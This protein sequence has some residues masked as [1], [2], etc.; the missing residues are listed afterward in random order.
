MS[1]NTQDWKEEFD[2]AFYRIMGTE[3]DPDGEP[4]IYLIRN[5]DDDILHGISFNEEK[6]QLK[7]FISNLLTSQLNSL[8]AELE[9]KIFRDK[10]PHEH[11]IDYLKRKNGYDWG[12]SDAQTIIGSKIKL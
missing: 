11:M 1:Q 3:T 8:I 10:S 12:I 4:N 9:E 7:S 5:S 2:E 6:E